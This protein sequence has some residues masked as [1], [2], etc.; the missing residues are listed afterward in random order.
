MRKFF[1][2]CILF[3]VSSMVYAQSTAVEKG[4]A[5]IS[6]TGSIS[7]LNGDLFSDNTTLSLGSDI[8][9]FGVKN[10]AVGGSFQY[11][12]SSGD[13]YKYQRLGVGPTLGYFFSDINPNIIP[14]LSTG[15]LINTTNLDDNPEVIRTQ[16]IASCGVILSTADHF[17]LN[18]K[19]SYRN[20]LEESR[21]GTFALDVGI[22]GMLY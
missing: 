17:G 16:G 19:V 22:T 11:Q 2:F 10:V 9:L 1:V 4:N 8:C 6:M 3:A 13:E 14:Y 15:L 21:R 20:I 7:R 12:R 5:L 18:V